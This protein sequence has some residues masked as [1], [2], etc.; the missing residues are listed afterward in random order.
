MTQPS[1]VARYGASSWV[2]HLCGESDTVSD[3]T[4]PPRVKD[5]DRP[6]VCTITSG[7]GMMVLGVIRSEPLSEVMTGDAGTV[8]SNLRIIEGLVRTG[9]LTS[10]SS[11]S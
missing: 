9:T 4:P 5:Q 11:K 2:S 3:E 10:G 6:G 8:S 7:S 1:T